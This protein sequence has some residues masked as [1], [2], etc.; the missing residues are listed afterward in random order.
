MKTIM[1]V[2]FC[3]VI[4][5]ALMV[6]QAA[7]FAQEEAP[8]CLE[9]T[10]IEGCPT[11]GGGSGKVFA[12]ATAGFKAAYSKTLNGGYVAHG[13]GMR[14]TG[15][16][17]IVVDDIPGG[18][19]VS[20]AYLFWALI[21]PTKLPG[22]SYTKGKINGSTIT[23]S[24]VGIAANP[25]WYVVG[26]GY[27]PTLAYRADVT[28]KMFKG[29]NG[30]YQLSG[31]ASGITDGRDPWENDDIGPLMEGAT[32]VIVY[33]HSMAP[34]TTIKIYNGASATSLQDARQLHVNITG[35]NATGLTG[36]TKTTFI[37]AD[38]QSSAEETGSTFFTTSLPVSW[39]GT[40]PNGSGYDHMYGNLW[41]TETVDLTYELDPPEPDF[42][43]TT[44]GDSD[45][46]IWVAQVAAYATGNQD[47]DGDKLLDGWELHGVNS[48]YLQ[49][50][51][52][53]PLHK[54]L[55]VE[56]DYMTGHDHLIAYGYLRDI[57]DVFNDAP[58]NNPDGTTGI[59]IHIDTGGAAFGQPAG[60]YAEFD[61]GG[62][63]G[64][65][66]DTY[67]GTLT[68]TG[69]YNWSEFQ[70][71]KDDNF[72]WNR[73]GIFHYMIFA[74]DLAPQIAGVS[75]ISRNGW[76][77]SKFIKGATDFII[78]MGSWPN[79][80]NQDER[81]GTFTHELGH[82]LG[83]RHGGND[84]VNYKPN[85]LSIMNYYYQTWGIW[86]D[87]GVHYDYSRIAPTLNESKLYEPGGLGPTAVGYGLRWYCPIWDEDWSQTSY[88]PIDWNCDDYINGN[89]KADINGDGKFTTLKSQSN[90][91]SI[92]FAGGGGIGSLPDAGMSV[93]ALM[94]TRPT[95]CLSYEDAQEIEAHGL[96]EVP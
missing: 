39:D 70:A 86:R 43:F 9:G 75:G 2:L 27:P 53:D 59:H 94:V 21:G 13:V 68:S 80:G 28:S 69:D 77:D 15:Y 92:T 17:T 4:C 26:Y 84:H 48:V 87:G 52:A 23:G 63:N 35:M 30:T 8:E 79:M 32:L 44:Q 60:T 42:W 65:P 22:F 19:K 29:G 31:F 61:L 83:L 64:V 76:P 50:F 71:I 45:I 51:G 20:K 38:G 54:D 66:E 85:Y 36:L 25:N 47:T 90:W 95:G 18:A 88:A 81:E 5:A 57:V 67:L 10:S 73:Y 12:E 33:S 72:A 11:P 89:V 78:S 74:H 37:G 93:S 46:L 55:F 96:F 49:S 62:G 7:V 14:N 24:L 41:D 16:G 58:V 56:A 1:R 34:K 40:V 3:V 91:A 6:P 82:N